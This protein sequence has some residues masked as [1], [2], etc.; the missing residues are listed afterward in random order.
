MHKLEKLSMKLNPTDAKTLT[1]QLSSSSS[2]LRTDSSF[3]SSSVIESNHSQVVDPKSRS[4]LS[5]RNARSTLANEQS[6]LS[7]FQ[8]IRECPLQIA[9]P[10]G[11]EAEPDLQLE[12]D[13]DKLFQESY[14]ILPSTM[15]IL[16]QTR[17]K[18][19]SRQ[20]SIKSSNAV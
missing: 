11:F 19:R 20:A 7:Q 3:V 4:P 16:K 9:N 5:E 14:G 8:L 2:Q 15:P 1:R 6:E 17:S 12:S 10:K 18:Q 13:D